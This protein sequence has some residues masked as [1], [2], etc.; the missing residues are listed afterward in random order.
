MLSTLDKVRWLDLPS[1]ADERGVLTPIESNIDIPFVI[2]RIFYMYEITANRG[3]HA[4][5]ET[6]QVAIAVAGAFWF[7]LSDTQNTQTYILDNPTRGLYLPPMVFLDEIIQDC[8]N[9]V[10]MVLASTHYND[11]KYIR[12]FDQY[13]RIVSSPR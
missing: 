7:R 10:C 13:A 12:S 4:H 11:E 5:R 3:G 1:F 9:S 6:E 8:P 2:K